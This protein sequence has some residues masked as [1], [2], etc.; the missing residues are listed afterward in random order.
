V[1][2]YAAQPGTPILYGS[3]GRHMDMRNGLVAMGGKEL[4]TIAG[5]EDMMIPA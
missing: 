4:Y 2:T 5:V 3:S 1:I